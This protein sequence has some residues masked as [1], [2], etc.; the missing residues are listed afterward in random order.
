MAHF[1]NRSLTL[2]KSFS[3]FFNRDKFTDATLKCEDQQILVHRILLS[4]CSCY[5][6]EKF[7]RTE[8]NV[9][10]PIENIKYD[11]LMNVLAYIYNGRVSLERLQA[12]S[13]LDAID[14]LQVEIDREFI[15]QLSD[16]EFH[17]GELVKFDT[18]PA[19]GDLSKLKLI[20]SLS[21]YRC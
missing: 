9:E 19:I 20:Q 15:A 12:K 7:K 11:D 10:L 2:N 16:E 4:H 17:E 18:K 1:P 3:S 6:A 21:L 13:F 5:F 8:T 14:A